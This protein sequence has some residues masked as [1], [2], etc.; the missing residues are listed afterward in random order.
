M[1]QQTAHATG[2]ATITGVRLIS[3]YVDD[4]QKALP[5]YTEVLG[6]SDYE[7]M[8]PVAAAFTLPDDR[9]LFLI[10][11]KTPVDIKADQVRCTFAFEVASVEA[12]TSKLRDAGAELVS[13]EPMQMNEETW[14]I[15]FRDPSGNLLEAI[16]GK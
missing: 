5:F 2:Q 11:R 10:G 4:Y 8:G 1:D 14:W 6:L 9:T 3:C 15:Q 16:G 13:G 12:F 7:P